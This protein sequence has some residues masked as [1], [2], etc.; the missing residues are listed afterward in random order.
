MNLQSCFESGVQSNTCHMK[1]A[2]ILLSPHD[3]R[4]GLLMAVLLQQASDVGFRRQQRGN[5][6]FSGVETAGMAVMG[7]VG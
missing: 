7:V 2:H 1:R 5:G 4:K 3:H 6:R